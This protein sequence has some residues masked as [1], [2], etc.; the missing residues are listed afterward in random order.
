MLKNMSQMSSMSNNEKKLLEAKLNSETAVAYWKELEV[1]FARGQLLLVDQ[2]LDLID[3]AIA[4]H[5]DDKLKIESLLTAGRLSQPSTDWVKLHCQPD[6]PFWAVV[7]A[8]FVVIQH[9]PNH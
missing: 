8:P 7:V 4:I 5:L 6:T 3:I 2:S 1:F 9:K